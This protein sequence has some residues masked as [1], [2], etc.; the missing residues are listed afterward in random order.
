MTKQIRHCS[1]LV[2]VLAA[3]WPALVG[4]QSDGVTEVVQEFSSLLTFRNETTE[5]ELDRCTLTIQTRL[6]TSC[7]Y[8][9]EPNWHHTTIVLSEIKELEWRPFREGYVLAVEFDVPLPSRLGT[10]ARRLRDGAQASFDFHSGESDRLLEESE[11][12]SN[13]VIVS[14]TGEPFEQQTRL[15]NLYFD[16]RPTTSQDFETIVHACN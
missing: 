12:R 1:K 4:A 16:E 7:I 3:V 13:V 9:T 8:P 11:L 6:R 15:M 14:C 10:L 5:V 2:G